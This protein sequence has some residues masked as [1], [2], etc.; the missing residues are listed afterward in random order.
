MVQ[1]NDNDGVVLVVQHGGSTLAARS[2]KAQEVR[3][4]SRRILALHYAIPCVTQTLLGLVNI[5]HEILPGLVIE[6]M[7]E[8]PITGR[9]GARSI[10]GAQP[11]R[12]PGG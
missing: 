1:L 2:S 5:V 3:H 7:P 6:I 4:A 11:N 10:V 8:W 9:N 12:K